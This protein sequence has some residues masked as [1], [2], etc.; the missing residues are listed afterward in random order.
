MLVLGAGVSGMAAARLA[1]SLGMRVTIY[2][3]RAPDE[4]VVDFG[5]ASGTWDP[6]LLEGTDLVIASPGFSERSH[7]VVE[8]L[9]RG[10][11]IW[12]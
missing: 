6:T 9:E 4:P 1:A 2:A 5:M 11:P 7:P 8:T 3:E 10:V 12:S